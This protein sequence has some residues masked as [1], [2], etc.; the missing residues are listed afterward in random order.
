MVSPSC[1]WARQG[2]SIHQTGLRMGAQADPMPTFRFALLTLTLVF[3]VQPAAALPV[4]PAYQ[5]K[6][7]FYSPIAPIGWHPASAWFDAGNRVLALTESPFNRRDIAAV[8]LYQWTGT[9]VI[10]QFYQYGPSEVG[11][12][13]LY[14]ALTPAGQP[15]RDRHTSYV[16]TSNVENTNS[17]LAKLPILSVL[18]A[19]PA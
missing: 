11:A 6:S 10:R 4:T 8:K 3:T 2:S 16:H 19:T 17:P 5:M 7:Y 12:G 15:V 14:T 18:T 1:S 13:N 9:K